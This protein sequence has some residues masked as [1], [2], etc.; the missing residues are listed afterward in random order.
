MLH[1]PLEQ[2]TEKHL[3]RLR[4]DGTPEGARLEFKQQVDLKTRAERREVAKDVSALANSVGGRIVYGISEEKQSD[5]TSTAGKIMPLTSGDVEESLENIIATTISPR[6][7]FRIHRVSVARGFCLVVEVYPSSGR[8]LHMV[9]AY[10]DQRFYRRGE[11]SVMRMTEAEIREA[12]RRIATS[13]LQ[14][15]V[16][17][18]REVAAESCL[19]QDAEESIII[20]PWYAAR[21]MADPRMI[22]QIGYDLGKK[23]TPQ[24][25]MAT[26]DYGHFISDMRVSPRGLTGLYYRSPPGYEKESPETADRYFAVTRSGVLHYSRQSA[27]QRQPSLRG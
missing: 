15:E 23:A 25:P 6:P 21:N 3:L 7:H 4:T 20:V 17:I 9:S 26:I 5:G 8:D 12:Y 2:L 18:E 16:S 24:G 13:T 22:Y 19:R 11:Q 14:L 1:I 10:G 27:T